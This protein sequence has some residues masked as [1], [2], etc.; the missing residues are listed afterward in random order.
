MSGGCGGGQISF[1]TLFTPL[2]REAFPLRCPYCEYSKTQVVGTNHDKR[3]GTRRRRHCQNCGKR[4]TSYERPLLSI[5]LLVK[6]DETREEFN[7]DKLLAGLRVACAKRPISAA[8]IENIAGEIEAELRQMERAEVESY[9]VGDLA[10]KKLK[11]LDEVAYI[12]YAIVYLG[13]Q[14]LDSIQIEIER[15][16]SSKQTKQ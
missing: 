7:R 5:P 4:F 10:I 12:R 16:L 6:R 9:V 1:V 2:C 3:G 8:S 13:L 15:L 14:D 11:A